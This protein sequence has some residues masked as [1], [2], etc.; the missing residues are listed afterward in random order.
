MWSQLPHANHGPPFEHSAFYVPSHLS[1][2]G[3]HHLHFSEEE[4][5]IVELLIVT[6]AWF[7]TQAVCL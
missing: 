2:T 3:V 6:T 4:T 5:D 7:S 1:P